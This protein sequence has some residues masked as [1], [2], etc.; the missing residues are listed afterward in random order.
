MP[1]KLMYFFCSFLRS[2]W[3]EA[4]T[5]RVCSTHGLY[6]I[7]NWHLQ[8]LIPSRDKFLKNATKIFSAFFKHFLGCFSQNFISWWDRSLKLGFGASIEP[9]STTNSP[10]FSLGSYR[11]K[12]KTKKIIKFL[13][14][15][16]KKH[17]ENGLLYSEHQTVRD[18]SFGLSLKIN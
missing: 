17:A 11:L 12:E 15:F 14:I 7:L 5:W 16:E 1:R 9:I 8:T 4:E 6:R 3:F 13:C 18:M 2:M 10:S